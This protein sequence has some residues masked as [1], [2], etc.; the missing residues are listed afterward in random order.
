MSVFGYMSSKLKKG[1]FLYMRIPSH[2]LFLFSPNKADTWEVLRPR[3]VV[4]HII[5]RV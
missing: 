4:D 5:L 2:Y 3:Y 1:K